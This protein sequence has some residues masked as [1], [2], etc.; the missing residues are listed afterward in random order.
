MHELCLSIDEFISTIEITRFHQN[1]N[2]SQ[3]NNMFYFV[4]RAF[5]ISTC[6]VHYLNVFFISSD[7]RIFEKYN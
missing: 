5:K 3:V 6:G 7:D 1:I 4:D 2:V